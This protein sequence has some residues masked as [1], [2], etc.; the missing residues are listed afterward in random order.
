[1]SIDTLPEQTSQAGTSD[2][3]TPAVRNFLAQGIEQVDSAI[4][5]TERRIADLG[6]ETTTAKQQLADLI[7]S[8]EQLLALV[9]KDESRESGEQQSR[10]TQVCVCGRIAVVHEVLGPVHEEDGTH[11]PALEAC[12]MPPLGVLAVPGRLAGAEGPV[13]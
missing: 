13:A 7:L 8:R 4:A 3:Y 1:M 10:P 12:Q 11:L 9:G 6:V 2:T 5:A